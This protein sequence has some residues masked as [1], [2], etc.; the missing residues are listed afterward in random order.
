MPAFYI[1]TGHVLVALL[2]S[3][4]PVNAPRKTVEDGPNTKTTATNIGYLGKPLALVWPSTGGC[5][6]LRSEPADGRSLSLPVSVTLTE[7][8]SK[9]IF[10]M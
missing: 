5:S 10:N 8:T 4:L 1:G 9:Y 3:Q 6:T 7:K 2:T